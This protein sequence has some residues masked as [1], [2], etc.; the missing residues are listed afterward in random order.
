MYC[1][2]PHFLH[3]QAPLAFALS[4]TSEVCLP[5]NHYFLLSCIHLGNISRRDLLLAFETGFVLP[6]LHPQLPPL[7]LTSQVI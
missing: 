5:Q 6:N 7:P 4:P 2:G 1:V 3:L